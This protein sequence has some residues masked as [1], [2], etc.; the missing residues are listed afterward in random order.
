M[1]GGGKVISR[2][3]FVGNEVWCVVTGADEFG[4][5][6]VGRLLDKQALCGVRIKHVQVSDL[7]AAAYL[8]EKCMRAYLAASP[9]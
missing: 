1:S 8:C 3:E 5:Q 6:H 7:F 2:D 9:P 4:V